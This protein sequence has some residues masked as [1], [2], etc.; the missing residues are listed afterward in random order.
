MSTKI[1][2]GSAS[3]ADPPA[4]RK[5]GFKKRKTSRPSMRLWPERGEDGRSRVG[6]SRLRYAFLQMLSKMKQLLL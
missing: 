6:V 5:E 4:S 2:P 1:H 3:L